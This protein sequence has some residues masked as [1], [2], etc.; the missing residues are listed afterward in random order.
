M[1]QIPTFLPVKS[2]TPS[3]DQSS[4]E[5]PPSYGEIEPPKK[6]SL[7][8]WL[9][10]ATL[11]SVIVIGAMVF[12]IKV[13][14]KPTANKSNVP[15]QRADLEQFSQ[16][17][18]LINTDDANRV[19]INSILHATNGVVLTPSAEPTN[20]VAGQLYLNETS[21]ILYYYNGLS[22]AALAIDSGDICRNANATCGFTNLNQVNQLI[23]NASI[24]LQ[25][26]QN[27]LVTASPTFAALT[28]SNG[29]IALG[30]N[31]LKIATGSTALTFTLPPNLGT[32]SQCLI[33]NGN[34]SLSFSSCAMGSGTAFI[35]GGNSLAATAVLGT[36]DNFGLSLEVNNVTVASFTNTGAAL[37]KNV[38][39]STTAFQVQNVAGTSV[40]NVDSINSRVGIGTASPGQMLEVVTGNI[41]ANGGDILVNQGA[42]LSVD[43]APNTY[44]RSPSANVLGF[45]TSNALQAQIASSGATLF[46]NSTNS[47]TALQVQNAAGSTTVFNVDTTNNRVGIG[48]ASPLY[49][50]QV[51]GSADDWI[52]KFTNTLGTATNVGR[53]LVVEAGDAAVA[54]HRALEIRDK[55]GTAKLTVLSAG[56]V[57]IGTTAPTNELEIK[58][59]DADSEAIISLRHTQAGTTDFNIR[60]GTNFV[61]TD[62]TNGTNPF[63][64]GSNAPSSS[65]VI[66]GT[67]GNVGI[68]TATT[69]AKLNVGGV[70]GSTVAVIINNGTSTGDILRLQDNGSS[71]FTVADG[72]GITATG[73]LT[74]TGNILPASASTIDLGSSSAEF[75]ELYIADDNGIRLGLDQDATLAYDELTDDRVELTGTGAS[76]FIEDRL[77]LGVQ[78]QTLTDD[79]T[80]NDALTPTATYVRIDV[81]ET[82]NVGVPDLTIS[83]TGAK[84]G[85]L[86][87][88]VN[89]E[90]D[91]SNDTFTITNSAGVVHLPGGATLTLGPNDSV[92]LIYMSDRWVTLSS[93]NN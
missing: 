8:R 40:F 2:D 64:I 76:L 17:A 29:Q 55:D 73:S 15:V 82:A 36:N 4:L 46:K 20:A 59:N 88:I 49:N 19:V 93:S 81:D 3:A 90:Q 68:G 9:G 32:A 57:G 86:L 77:S 89:N 31:T 12:G 66:E 52:A 1:Q 56:N 41:Y 83:E 13:I 7:W 35:Q 63:L 39:N 85:Q 91:G 18:A 43:G 50:L 72:G 21:N 24:A 23:Q 87:A 69:T 22:Y 14:R 74:I 78:T 45:Y 47:T 33:G 71:V 16:K 80:A 44:I 37:F 65:L 5:S 75:D 27:L 34:G 53:G 38:S 28:L 67:T 42:K 54:T 61:I 60:A 84:D 10:T 79:G 6:S 48:T 25:L 62:V 70:T 58:D 26:P 51:T 11:V 92:T 30:T